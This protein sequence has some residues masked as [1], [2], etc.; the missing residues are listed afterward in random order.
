[1]LPF[2]QTVSIQK[3]FY[4]L[5]VHLFAPFAVSLFVLRQPYISYCLSV[6]L[7]VRMS[8]YLICVFICVCK[9]RYLYLPYFLNHLFTCFN[10]CLSHSQLFSALSSIYPAYHLLSFA[11]L[12]YGLFAY[13]Y[14]L[15]FAFLYSSSIYYRSFC[16]SYHRFDP[17]SMCFRFLLFLVT[18]FIY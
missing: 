1:M 8:V 16:L 4:S 3:G 5:I 10:I 11:Y 6:Y 18:L 15:S 13:L 2:N 14:I 7:M 9:S 17:L 12:L